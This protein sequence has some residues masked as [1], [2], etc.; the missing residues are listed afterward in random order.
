MDDEEL[1]RRAIEVSAEARRHGNH[2]FGALLADAS[3]AVV[4]TAENSVTT[5]RDVTHHA[6]LNLVRL[7]CA[8]I[9]YADLPRHT[10]YSSCEPCAMCSGAIYWAG[11]GRVVYALS[12][13]R[14]L[15]LTGAHPDNPTLMLP[16]RDV[17]AAGSRAT[18]VTGPLLEDDAAA[19]HEDFWV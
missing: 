2:P 14:L 17:F 18:D 1:L 11:I 13:S 7:A 9:P 6:E 19:H 8:S 3:G 16:S 10:L 4:L 12:E 5:G 15:S